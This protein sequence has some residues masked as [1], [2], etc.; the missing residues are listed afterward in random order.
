MEPITKALLTSSPT[1]S[2]ISS[3]KVLLLRHANSEFNY[4][5]SELMK[6]DP[7]EDE[8]RQIRTKKELRDAPLSQLGIKQWEKAQSV[9]NSLKVEVVV[10]SPLRR[11]IETAYYVFKTHPNFENIKF[12]LLPK[13][14]EALDTTCDI[15]NNILDTI[16]E[17]KKKFINF[18]C[19]RIYKYPD[20]P[21]FFLKDIPEEKSL[22]VMIDKTAN[23]DDPFGTN[24]FDLLT[25]VIDQNYPNKSESFKNVVKRIGKVKTSLGKILTTQMVEE[26]S[27][28]VVVGH[29]YYFKLWTGKW[30]KPVEEYDVVPEPKEFKWLENWEFYPDNANFP[31]PNMS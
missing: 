16:N 24:A 2:L 3:S 28:L 30:E 25:E 11:A 17:F 15:P 18:D 31:I 5:M 1:E 21:H 8:L 9:A 10:V 13:L 12:I 26:D 23:P 29:S 19:S 6:T 7:S 14:R 27:K 20:I 4:E 22:K